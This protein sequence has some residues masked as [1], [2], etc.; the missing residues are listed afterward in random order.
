MCINESMSDVESMVT[1][2]PKGSILGPILFLVYTV[3][4]HYLLEALGASFHFYADDTQI[5]T[6]VGE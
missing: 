5:Y 1:W 4:L 2:V 3:D 6:S